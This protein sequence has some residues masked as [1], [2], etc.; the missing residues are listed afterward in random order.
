[1]LIKKALLL[2]GSLFCSFNSFGGSFEI[3]QADESYRDPL[4][5]KL[6]ADAYTLITFASINKRGR[7]VEHVI[8]M[9]L[10]NTQNYQLY[11]NVA[12]IKGV[13]PGTLFIFV[14]DQ[15]IPYDGGD[16][17]LSLVQG[18]ELAILVFDSKA[19][20]PGDYKGLVL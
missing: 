19:L 14:D 15:L 1:M 10:S 16:F 12:L 4:G 9:D 3:P 7:L 18:Q 13:Q 20:E 6:D 2:I 8:S 11:D 17:D 5:L